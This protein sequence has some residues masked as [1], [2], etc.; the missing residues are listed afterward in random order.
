[1]PGLHIIVGVALDWWGD[2]AGT[3]LGT[4][5]LCVTLTNTGCVIVGH[6]HD[7]LGWAVHLAQL[8]GHGHQV[9]GAVRH[10]DGAV[11]GLVDGCRGGEA[12]GYIKWPRLIQ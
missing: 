7:L 4:G 6:N 12:F 1:M 11:G 8:A 5:L 2:C 10:D 3:V 9:A